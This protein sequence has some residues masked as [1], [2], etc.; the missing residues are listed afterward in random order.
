MKKTPI[1]FLL[2]WS[3]S[4]DLLASRFS[5][6]ESIKVAAI[7]GQNLT[8][9]SS[10]NK[11]MNYLDNAIDKAVENG[12]TF[13]IMP[14]L[15]IT[16]PLLDANYAESI[17]ETIPG[18]T[19]LH[20]GA[21][22]MKYNVWIV[23]SVVEKENQHGN[24]HFV[25]QVLLDQNGQVVKKQR[26]MVEH[27]FGDDGQF[28]KVGDPWSVVDST[29]VGGY[30][31]GLLS[32]DDLRIG[33]PRL[34]A[35]GAKIIFV[36]A[37]WQKNEL[38]KWQEITQKLA[39]TNNVDIVIANRYPDFTGVYHKNGVINRASQDTDLVISALTFDGLKIRPP[40]GLPS[41]PL[42]TNY[43]FT[44]KL[45]TLGRDIFFDTSLSN[46]KNVSCASCHSPNLSFANAK[47][48]AQIADK[49]KS[50]RNVP[51]LLNVAYRNVLLWDGS[52]NSLE[53]QAKFPMTHVN[54]INTHYLEYLNRIRALSHYVNRFKE[55]GTEETIEFDDI[56]RALAT[57]QRS[58]LSGNSPFDRYQ[59]ANQPSALSESQKRGLTI[60]KGKANCNTCHLVGEKWALFEDDSFHNTGVGYTAEGYSD[61]G[62]GQVSYGP[63]AGLFKTPSLRNVAL[64]APYMHD[65]SI[66][67]L[68]EVVQ[69]YNE[70]GQNNPLLDKNILPLNLSSSE[71]QDLVQFLKALNGDHIFTG[72]GEKI[73]NKEPVTSPVIATLKFSA[74]LGEIEN[75]QYR[76]TKLVNEAV[77]SGAD[78]VVLPEYSITGRIGALEQENHPAMS[79]EV[80]ANNLQLYK[81]WA[82]TLDVWI[83]A[84]MIEPKGYVATVLIDELGNVRAKHRKVRI[85][86]PG[87]DNKRLPGNWN[88][89]RIIS[90]PFGRLGILSGD[91]IDKGISRL[92]K[93]GAEV[94]LVSASWEENDQIDWNALLQIHRQENSVEVLVS[95]LIDETTHYNN[96][97]LLSYNPLVN[98]EDRRNHSELPLGLST[99]PRPIQNGAQCTEIGRQ[100]FIDSGLSLDGNTSC[101]TCH[102]P[103]EAFGDDLNLS[104][105][106]FE[107]IG[108]RNTPSLLNLAYKSFYFW[109]GRVATLE[110]QLSHVIHSWAEMDS[111][112]TQL[113]DYVNSTEKYQSAFQVLSPTKEID[114]QNIAKCIVSYQLSLLSGN[115]PFDRYY[116]GGDEHSISDQAKKG[117]EVF[118]NKG[119]CIT[120]HQVTPSESQFTDHQFHN[121]GVGFQE[122][123]LY[124][125]YGGD[126]LTTPFAARD[127]F[128]GEYLTPSLRNVSITAPYMHDGSFTTLEEIV[129]YYNKGAFLN[130]PFQDSHIKPLKLSKI[131]QSN[132]VEFLKTLT[133]D[134]QYNPFGQKVVSN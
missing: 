22:A 80:Q 6:G 53:N 129:S 38:V 7:D 23:V 49:N 52:S 31:V 14:E 29:D 92:T 98:V 36:S 101:A 18:P 99:P 51:S 100:L 72:T 69:F 27:P 63:H 4:F 21:L 11:R 128:L 68:S 42:P 105:G 111:N 41:V 67:T 94:I 60:F 119:G 59:Y 28:H 77:S 84:T 61:L 30:R 45:V 1:L 132:L 43:E 96:K 97:P 89:S 126:G 87:R 19:T 123:F 114:Y 16:G 17:R 107:R 32:G 121:T 78:I 82:V 56:A 130:N 66:N 33:V 88:D 9:L 70:G 35:R 109:D 122:R 83:V 2:L 131:E 79:E 3:I 40:L 112:H 81:Q 50:L 5:L 86:T 93:L 127:Q 48:K 108:Q 57:Y 134:Q 25:T 55:S 85:R 46:S 24:G 115:S 73:Y 90:S 71:K 124:L 102:K 120:C 133:G 113:L 103:Q 106:V 47:D 8:T 34:A 20:F 13:I 26:K 54:E 74:E 118:R 44:E 62:W 39:K 64:T 91:D 110:D 65:G 15:V 37:A 76:L 95:E 116:Y 117:Y 75:N 58:L 10:I 125:G 104:K 12:A